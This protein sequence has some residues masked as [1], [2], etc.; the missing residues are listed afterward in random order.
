M[1]ETTYAEWAIV[2]FFFGL[3]CAYAF[4]VGDLVVQVA[5]RLRVRGME[6]SFRK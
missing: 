6:T 3:M 2:V 4:G 1:S 5:V